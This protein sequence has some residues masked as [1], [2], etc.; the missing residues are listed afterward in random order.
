LH[1]HES[2]YARKYI[3]SKYATRIGSLGSANSIVI[4][5]IGKLGSTI[6]LLHAGAQQKQQ[7]LQ[8]WVSS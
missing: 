8:Q 6:D 4:I 2:S 7:E 3:I 5:S 1:T